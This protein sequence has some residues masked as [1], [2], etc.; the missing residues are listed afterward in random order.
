MSHLTIGPPKQAAPH[1]RR[2][3]VFVMYY[4][5]SD[6]QL[7]AGSTPSATFVSFNAFLRG[8]NGSSE[9]DSID[10][11]DKLLLGLQII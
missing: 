9:F 4:P 5:P 7:A 6:V 10:L 8:P 1:L 3:T 2:M 11:L